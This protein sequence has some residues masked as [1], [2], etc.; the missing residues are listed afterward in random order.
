MYLC[1]SYTFSERIIEK[2]V[3]YMGI[4]NLETC[5]QLNLCV[6]DNNEKTLEFSG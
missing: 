3:D 1:T 2:T 4:K 6:Q 5:H